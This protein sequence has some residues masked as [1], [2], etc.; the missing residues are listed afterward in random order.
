MKEELLALYELQNVDVK[1]AE[2]RSAIEALDGAKVMKHKYAV[3]KARAEA[4]DKVLKDYEKEQRDKELTLKSI[5]EKRVAAEKRKYGGSVS[6]SKELASLEKEIE[7][8]KQQQSEL[9]GRVLELYDL[10][11]DA[12]AKADAAL[13]LLA[14]VE[15]HARVAI[16]KEMAEKKRL[17]GELAELTPLREQAAARVTDKHLL[18]RYASVVKR[19]G[20][21]GIAKIVD[22]KC[23]GCR[24]VITAFIMR[25]LFED[26]EY[27]CCENCG[28]ILLLDGNK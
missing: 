26:K 11:P 8:L 15:H 21:T 18:S 13:E 10:V 9:D 20:S 25:Q 3:A 17:E 23:E 19:T 16:K 5:D 2:A 6:N 7:Y 28:R 14:K 1:I 24:V 27:E 22:G 4:A 12:K